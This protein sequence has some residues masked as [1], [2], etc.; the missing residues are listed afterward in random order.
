MKIYIKI[1]NNFLYEKKMIMVFRVLRII[2]SSMTCNV[3]IKTSFKKNI[4]QK[5][6][7]PTQFGNL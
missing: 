1:K 7:T 6:I 2:Y 3:I 5:F 4:K